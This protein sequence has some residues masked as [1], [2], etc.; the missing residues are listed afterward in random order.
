[1]DSKHLSDIWFAEIF[2]ISFSHL[3]CAPAMLNHKLPFLKTNKSW[4]L[5]ML[6]L[7]LETII[8]P[9][10]IFFLLYSYLCF[11]T[12]I[13]YFLFV[14]CFH[15]HQ[16]RIYHAFLYIATELL[17]QTSQWSV[18]FCLSLSRCNPYLVCFCVP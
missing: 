18:L 11:K 6:F 2:P 17:L 9:H 13:N 5:I 4:D 16:S 15:T 14:K 3:C 12:Q 8:H 1:M 10:F 7:L